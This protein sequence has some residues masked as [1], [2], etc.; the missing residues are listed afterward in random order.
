MKDEKKKEIAEI[1]LN[2]SHV[3]LYPVVSKL[4]RRI[5]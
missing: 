5:Y 3:I 1:D 4:P 2:T